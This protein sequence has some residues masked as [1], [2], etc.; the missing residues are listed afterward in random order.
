MG[1][2]L[3]SVP[4]LEEQIESLRPGDHVCVISRD[5]SQTNSV[6]VPFVRRCLARKEMC[7]YAIGE[8]A[9]EDVAAELTQAGIDIEQAREQGALTLLK[10]REFMPL[11]KFD[12]SAFIALWKA[13]AQQA[14]NAGF[15]GSGFA[16]EMTWELELDVAHDA[17]IEVEQRLNT[18]FFP[19]ARAIALCIYD[20][21]RLSAEYL[22]AA[23]RS[24]PLV[25]VDDKLIT[26]PFYEPPE[27]IAQPS[28]A[29]TVDWMI[30]QLARL[31]GDREELRRSHDRFRAL[32]ENASDGIAV[33][34]AEGRILYEGPSV[35]RLLGYKPE[36]MVGR[37]VGAFISQEDVAPLTEKIRCA[38]ENPKEG[39]T[40]RLHVRRRDRSIIDIEAVGRRLRD[41]PDPPCVVFNWRDI[42]ER[43]HFEQELER[44]RDAALEASRLKSAFIA[45]MSHEIRTPL[46]IIAGYTD[47]VGEHLAE[48]NDESQ[49][50]YVEGIQRACSR[51]SRTIDNILDISKIEA[52]AFNLAPAQLEIGRL[53]EH[54]LADFRVIT[55]RKGIALSCTIDTP[56]AAILFDEYC[57]TQA[58]TNLLDNALKFTERGGVACR[59]YRA[60]DASL[61][62]E[63]RDTGIGIG[64]EYL[65]RLFQPFSQEHSGTARKF[66]G[67][68]LGLALTRKYL[69]LNGAELSVRSE[70]GKGTTF[71]IDFSRGS[72]VEKRSD[73]QSVD[74]LQAVTSRPAILVVED[75]AE[76]QVYMRTMLRRQYD[77][78]IAASGAEM[79]KV[80]EVQP[81]ISLILLDVALSE[82]ED[83]VSLIQYLRGQERWKRIP[84]IAV[85]AC[86]TP[87]HRKR[88]LEAGCDDYLPKP[89]NRLEL[90]AKIDA[91]I[92]CPRSVERLIPL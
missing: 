55:E 57:L 14:L 6:I 45:N 92:S 31:A 74:R 87:E 1:S 5:A 85:T 41:P 54:L 42:S 27:L 51:L 70:K 4:T 16:V 39:Q 83:G 76:T 21:Q 7:F 52:G 86:A 72:E 47:L 32:I 15:Y 3:F 37:H 34:D 12:S 8:R 2:T 48:H 23:L 53:L 59:L 71:T 75:D 77:V 20:R 40:L 9:V 33:L 88:A 81:D 60:T 25:I 11:E 19:N 36:E 56:G 68:G 13:R 73:S 10:N 63:I 61:C 22:R 43:V 44:A 58:L 18:E 64:Q 89:V 66:Q 79:R 65:P 28:E 30:A 67:S 24:H 78:V 46:N 90:L 84:I 38:I 50:D 82:D 80:L 17:L 29:A 62:L 49:N 26:D 35:E 91:L 69:E